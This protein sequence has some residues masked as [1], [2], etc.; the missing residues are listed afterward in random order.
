MNAA[1]EAIS[2]AQSLQAVLV[3]RP[4]G[5]AYTPNAE[6]AIQMLQDAGLNPQ[7]VVASIVA[8]KRFWAVS[9]SAAALTALTANAPIA[10]P[11]AAKA[12]AAF[13]PNSAARSPIE[14]ISLDP[15]CN[16]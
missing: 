12:K 6:Q 7:P 16:F 2:E 4:T 14:S 13:L 10:A 15:F 5:N 8:A 11:A 1:I 9:S 3:N